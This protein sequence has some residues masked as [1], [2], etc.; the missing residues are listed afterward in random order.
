MIP[1]RIT[2]RDQAFKR[3]KALP[4]RF[5]KPVPMVDPALNN[6]YSNSGSSG[7]NHNSIN[8]ITGQKAM[9]PSIYLLN[10]RSLFPKL[11]EL[12]ALLATSPVDLV[13]IT[14]SWLRNDIDDSLLSISA[15]N[16]FRKDRVAGRGGGICF[17]LNN[18]IPCKQRLDL[19]NPIFEC[20]WL[21]LRPKRLPR[22]LS[23]ITICVVYH[24]PGRP[25]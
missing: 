6:K 7:G 10:A 21:T 20:L 24:P 14:E 9:L 2:E 17:Y 16:L 3:R 11:D 15:F 25:T 18:V 4:A 12:T 22:P 8:F 13:A 23:G 1:V 5:I 19:E